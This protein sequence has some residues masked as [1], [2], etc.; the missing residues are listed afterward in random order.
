MAHFAS[1]AP[2][3]SDDPDGD[4]QDNAFELIAGHIPANARSLLTVEPASP[5][6]TG[7]VFRLN[8]VRPGVRYMLES[9]TDLAAWDR[10][11]E[12]TYEVEGP[13]ALYDERTDAGERPRSFYRVTVESE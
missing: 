1:L 4:G 12:N 6:A 7:G 8:H 11:S 3:G 2:T 13:G 5:F 10:L 9:S